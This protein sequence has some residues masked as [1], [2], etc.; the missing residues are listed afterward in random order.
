MGEHDLL[1]DGASFTQDMQMRADASGAYHQAS[2]S[3][4]LR[5]AMLARSRP[6]RREYGTIGERLATRS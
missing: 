3:D 4:K 1:S 5:A 6:T 2:T